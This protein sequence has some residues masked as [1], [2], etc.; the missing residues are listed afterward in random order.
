M[1]PSHWRKSLEFPRLFRGELCHLQT[2]TQFAAVNLICKWRIV[3]L[4]ERKLPYGSA[5]QSYMVWS[6]YFQAQGYVLS[7]RDKCCGAERKH[8]EM[9]FLVITEFGLDSSC[10][11]ESHWITY[12]TSETLF[13]Y[14]IQVTW[15]LT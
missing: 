4:W 6:S 9:F 1:R 10:F 13:W 11:F 3:F 5:H 7:L 2:G 8:S 15:V 14:H 12:I